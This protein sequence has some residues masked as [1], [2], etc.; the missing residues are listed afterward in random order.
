[1]CA[2]APHPTHNIDIRLHVKTGA[3]QTVRVLDPR[4]IDLAGDYIA[5]GIE[6]SNA[7]AHMK[8]SDGGPLVPVDAIGKEQALLLRASDQ[9]RLSHATH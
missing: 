4:K 6:L 5:Y 7:N 9:V 3:V 8:A 1:M 2:P